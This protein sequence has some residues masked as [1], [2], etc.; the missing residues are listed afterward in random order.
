MGKIANIST[1]ECAGSFYIL[2][3]ANYCRHTLT[4]VSLLYGTLAQPTFRLRAT[5]GKG[6]GGQLPLPTSGAAHMSQRPRGRILVQQA[7]SLLLSFCR[8][9]LVHEG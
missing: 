5:R 1:T 3:S 9:W 8:A 7:K 6:T 4:S 2:L